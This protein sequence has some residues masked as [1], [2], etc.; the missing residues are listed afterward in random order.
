MN[1][2][3]G[4]AMGMAQNMTP[5]DGT[6]AVA[7]PMNNQAAPGNVDLGVNTTAKFCSEC[8]ASVTGKFCSNC[9]KEIK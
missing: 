7:N 6:S 4:N 1:N 9:G 2:N 3:C 5:T 8:G